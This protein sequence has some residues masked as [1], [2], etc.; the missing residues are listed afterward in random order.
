MHSMSPIE[1][2]F[3]LGIISDIH[4]NYQNLQTALI[5]LGLQ[6]G[7]L[8]CLGDLVSD[9]SSENDKCI[10]LIRS[11]NIPSVFGQHDDTCIKVNQPPISEESR[12]YLAQLAEVMR[13]ENVLCVHD[14]PLPKAKL[15][16]GMW[17]NGSYIRTQQE[18]QMVFDDCTEIDDDVYGSATNWL[19]DA[20]RRGEKILISCAAGE[21]RSVSIAIGFLVLSEGLPFDEACKV[22]FNA[23]PTAYPH[24]QTL[25]SVAGHCGIELTYERI[26]SIY[27]TIPM[28]PPFPW[29][30]EELRKQ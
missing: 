7:E 26:K 28:L 2:P 24:P 16:Q 21:S 1:K 20:W 13:Y 11:L 15:G 8:V 4:G 17:K 9:S 3:N 27:K 25:S 5:H 6:V 10:G 18:A 30:D 29:S 23:I 22:V 12:T 14:N 19:L